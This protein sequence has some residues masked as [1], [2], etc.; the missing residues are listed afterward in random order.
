MKTIWIVIIG[1]SC[2][3]LGLALGTGL[4]MQKGQ[5]MV[6]EGLNIALA[7]SNIDLQ[8]NFNET[9]F[10]E[11]FNKTIIPKLKKEFSMTTEELAPIKQD[12]I[13]IP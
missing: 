10:V 11:E 12:P 8:I 3:L 13:I 1:M 5:Y 2:F 7:D 6:F 4:G 9:K